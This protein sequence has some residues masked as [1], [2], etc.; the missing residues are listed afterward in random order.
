MALSM[1]SEIQASKYRRLFIKRFTNSFLLLNSL[2]K[3]IN[4]KNIVT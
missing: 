2:K 1:V 3:E 4:S